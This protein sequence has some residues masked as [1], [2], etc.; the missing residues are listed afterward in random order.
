MEDIEDLIG[1]GDPTPEGRNN[2]R[3]HVVPRAK[4]FKQKDGSTEKVSADS[5]V[6]GNIMKYYTYLNV[7]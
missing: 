7:K 1:S 2:A 6:P 4:K 5:I 3:K